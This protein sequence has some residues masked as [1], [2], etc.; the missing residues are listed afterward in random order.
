MSPARRDA[1]IGAALFAAAIAYFATSIGSVFELQDEGYFNVLNAIT[2]GGGL[3]HRDFT[4][5]YGPGVYWLNGLV[6]LVFDG[7]LLAVRFGVA[8][9]KAAAVV[10]TYALVRGLTSVPF[11]VFGALLAIVFWGRAT[12]TL[13]S[14]YAALYTIPLCMASCWL[15]M[16]AVERR[17][18]R[19]L[20]FA[21][22]LLGA[23]VLFKH[24][25]AML[26]IGGLGVALWSVSVL[27]S[28]PGKGGRAD[29][30]WAL[31]PLAAAGIVI[32]VP[33]VGML[34]PR[35][36][37][38]HF[39]PFHLLLAVVAAG[40]VRHRPRVPLGALVGGRLLPF[41]LGAAAVPAIVVVVYA[42]AGGL[43]GLAHDL[44]VLSTQM[45]NYYYPSLT[46]P[47]E[48]AL[49]ALGVVA[50]ASA[51]LL[52]LRGSG[53]AALVSA[54]AGGL[55]LGV[56]AVI[57]DSGA[58]PGTTWLRPEL[59]DGVFGPTTVLAAGSLLAPMVLRHPL[60]IGALRSALPLL[61]LGSML[62]LQAFPR[63]SFSSWIVEAAVVPVL[64]WAIF[65]WRE[66]GISEERGTGRGWRHVAATALVLSIPLWMGSHAT[67]RS[68]PLR[69]LGTPERAL[70]LPLA[71][72]I[73]LDRAKRRVLEIGSLQA[74]TAHVRETSAADAPVLL[75]GNEWMAVYL[76]ER[77]LLF[78]TRSGPLVLLALGMLP[79]AATRELDEAAMLER[80]QTTAEALVID[81]RGPGARRMRAALPRLSDW[82]DRELTDETTF[83]SFRVLRRP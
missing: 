27:E 3:P 4:D 67:A 29:L 6:H 76:S 60:P 10:L 54:V 17:A 34:A 81:D 52:G 78:P 51:G 61:F 80:L 22:L 82:I 19:G 20:L 32:V 1:A 62:L 15:L 69:K 33:F 30:V 56:A 83:G 7:Q 50:L 39:A 38:L 48:T 59:F 13:T 23:A 68:A 21:G 73:S 75:L 57:H 31:G 66:L 2:A 14:P 43:P 25:L 24:S 28:E 46:P 41:G 64:V 58:T 74:V 53:R 37:L 26:C 70:D 5:L 72:G 9:F 42:I 65:R 11:A 45:E 77:P 40:I 44:F 49:F 79:E 12:W 63:A 71:R 18:W 8:I 47:R 36:Y 16:R 35:D 55:A